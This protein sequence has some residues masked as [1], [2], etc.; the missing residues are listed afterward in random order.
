MIVDK[1]YYVKKIGSYKELESFI[2]EANQ[3][4]LDIISMVRDANVYII[5][6]KSHCEV[7][8]EIR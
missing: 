2:G 8:Y 3:K 6:Y 5:I 1:K 4:D 7:S